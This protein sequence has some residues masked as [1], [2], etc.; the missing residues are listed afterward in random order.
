[1]ANNIIL[2][3]SYQG[4]ALIVPTAFKGL[5]SSNNIKKINVIKQN[6]NIFFLKIE[7]FYQKSSPHMPYKVQKNKFRPL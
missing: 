7:I 4:K 2:D 3:C 1:M 5:W 6:E